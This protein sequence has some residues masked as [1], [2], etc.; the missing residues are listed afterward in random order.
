MF[1]LMSKLCINPC[2]CNIVSFKLI[3][4]SLDYV[5]FLHF[6]HF[7]KVGV[8]CLDSFSQLTVV[9]KLTFYA[10]YCHSYIKEALLKEDA[11][12]MKSYWNG[13]P[14]VQGSI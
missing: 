4:F 14:R 5:H 11:G 9:L 2:L 6:D 12:L 3:L 8:A 13:L 1:C 10:L 7:E